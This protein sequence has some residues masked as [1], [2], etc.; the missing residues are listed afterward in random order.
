ML[1]KKNKIT[2]VFFKKLFN[3][4]FFFES[5]SFS[6]RYYKQTRQEFGVAVI[7]SKKISGSAVDRNLLKRRFFSIISNNSHLLFPHASYLVY[8]KKQAFE[9]KKEDLELEIIHI[10]SRIH[11]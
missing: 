4:G 10:L 8:P 6:L 3:K 2:S 9:T 5:Q 11:E 7:V 1:A